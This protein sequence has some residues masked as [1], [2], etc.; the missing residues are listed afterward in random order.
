MLSHS[1]DGFYIVAKFELPKV[2]D[3]KLVTFQFDFKCSYLLPITQKT[4]A[5]M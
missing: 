5:T 1:F 4:A 2:E 3:L